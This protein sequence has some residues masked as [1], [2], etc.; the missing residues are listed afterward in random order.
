MST[1]AGYGNEH[2]LSTEAQDRTY[3]RGIKQ[4][5]VPGTSICGRTADEAYDKYKA[6]GAT[7]A[8]LAEFARNVR[9]QFC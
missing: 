9:K 2:T 6:Y 8:Q 4:T 5:T 7:E 1:Y 3:L